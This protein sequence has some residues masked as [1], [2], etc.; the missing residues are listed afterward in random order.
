MPYKMIRVVLIEK[1]MTKMIIKLKLV[2]DRIHKIRGTEDVL[3][4]ISRQ[5]A[6]NDSYNKMQQTII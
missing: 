2:N 6:N 3:I 4:F 5:Q 1:M